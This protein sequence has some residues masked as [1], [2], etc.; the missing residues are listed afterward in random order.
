MRIGEDVLLRYEVGL[1]LFM[2][3][4]VGNTTRI[5][6]SYHELHSELQWGDSLQL[7]LIVP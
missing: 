5:V 7:A 1:M 3:F 4:Q 6:G 2:L